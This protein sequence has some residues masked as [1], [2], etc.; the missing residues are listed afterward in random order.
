[1][2]YF[3]VRCGTA[4]FDGGRALAAKFDAR[5]TVTFPGATSKGHKNGSHSVT[6]SMH[7]YKLADPNVFSTDATTFAK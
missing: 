3:D 4:N 5:L 1:M 2:N 7:S 6:A